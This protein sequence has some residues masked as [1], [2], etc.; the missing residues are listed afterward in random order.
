MG[1]RVARRKRRG[2]PAAVAAGQRRAQQRRVQQQLQTAIEQVVQQTLEQALMDE[3]TAL[4]GRERYARR[5]TGPQQR[6][7][8]ACSRCGLDWAP[9]LRRAGSY[10]RQVLTLQGLVSLRVPR[11]S[12][13]CGG[14][15][16]LE[17]RTC[18]LSVSYALV[19]VVSALSTCSQKLNA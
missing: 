11:L 3:V 13:I 19:V 9:R 14:T 10:P 4:L 7:G 16:P 17:F 12:C 6:A 2:K 8:V 5:R 1:T 18:T 15:V